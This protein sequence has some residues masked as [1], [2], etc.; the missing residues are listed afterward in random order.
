MH[1]PDQGSA[2]ASSFITNENKKGCICTLFLFSAK[3][4]LRI[5]EVSLVSAKSRL[6]AYCRDL[7]GL[8]N[9]V[10]VEF[11]PLVDRRHDAELYHLVAHLAEVLVA[12]LELCLLLSVAGHRLE[13][14]TVLVDS[15]FHSHHNVMEL[16]VVNV[17]TCRPL[18]CRTA[19]SCCYHLN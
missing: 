2:H 10:W 1:E 15:G 6:G 5:S 9:H 17:N 16:V 12:L 11:T 13:A 7:Y 18:E 19:H 14:Y 3:L 4:R 8:L